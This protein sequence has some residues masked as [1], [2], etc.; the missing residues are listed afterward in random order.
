MQIS[1]RVQ[2]LHWLE[3]QWY[4]ITRWH[5][6]LWPIS[7][8]FGLI[9]LAR[10][11]AYRFGLLPSF[12]LPVPVIVVGNITV[13]GTGKTP[14]V[15]WLT[16]FL[17]EQGFRPGIVSRGYGS[18]AAYPRAALAAS[19]PAEVGDEPVLLAKRSACPVWVG[20]DRVA[21]AHA[22]LKAHPDCDV[23][24]CDD[25]LQH[26]RLGRDVEI[27]VVDSQRRYGNGLLLPAGP[28]RERAG[29]LKKMDAVL[30]NGGGWL[31]AINHF[32]MQLRGD[33]FR[34]LQNPARYAEA[35][36][37]AGKRLYALA[38]I[39][40][41]GRFFG[42]LRDLGLSCREHAY[43]DHYAY[44]PQDL[45]IDGVDAVLMTEKDG[46]KC[47][48]FATPYC[49]ELVVETEIDPVVGYRVLD[50][51]RKCHGRKTT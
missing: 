1:Q 25:G 15:L 49:W 20:L 5:I 16:R 30:F 23:L 14:A 10:R 27:A 39:G 51:I 11:L 29:R 4:R 40:N 3:A 32:A 37:F 18:V 44:R 31:Q 22:L 42:H 28:L 45:N 12:R 19:D 7:V 38:G 17:Q 2:F 9:V 36:D 47:A 13:G 43:P 35:A 48:H 46:V 33:R 41:P 24:I 8:V 50:K 34:N 21:V 6:L 26:Y